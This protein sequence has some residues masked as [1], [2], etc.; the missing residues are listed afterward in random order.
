MVIELNWFKFFLVRNNSNAS[1]E[2]DA[3][4]CP[5]YR[6]NTFKVESS[7]PS[8]ITMWGDCTSFKRSWIWK[9]SKSLE[10]FDIIWSIVAYC[11]KIISSTLN[12]FW[13]FDSEVCRLKLCLNQTMSF[14]YVCACIL[15]LNSDV[16][17]FMIFG[18]DWGQTTN[19]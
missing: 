17:D 12:A 5:A 13:M 18:N 1:I 7:F 15:G 3:D 16:F 11:V 9:F 4:K 14:G 6:S 8:K 2:N 19:I 10:V